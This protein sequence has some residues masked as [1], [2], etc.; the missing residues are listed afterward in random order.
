VIVFDR[1][2]NDNER[3]GIEHYLAEKYRRRTGKLWE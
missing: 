3:A 1:C 2:L